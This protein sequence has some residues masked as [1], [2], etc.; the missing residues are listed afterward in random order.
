MNTTVNHHAQSYAV[1]SIRFKDENKLF[2]VDGDDRDRVSARKWH[3]RSCGGYIASGETVDKSRYELYLHNF[4]MDRM[5]FEG[6]G[7]KESVDHINRHG[8]DN[9]KENLRLV[10]QTTQNHN[11]SKKERKVVLPEGCGID[12]NEMPRTVSYIPPESGHHD[13]FAVDVK[14]FPHI[15]NGRYRWKST[16]NGNVSLRNKLHHALFHLKELVNKYPELIG[17]NDEK[18]QLAESF[19]EII[20]KSGF[21]QDVI[22]A[23]LIPTEMT[24]SNFWNDAML[25]PELKTIIKLHDAGQKVANDLPDDMV[26]PPYACYGKASET[27]GDKFYINEGHP[28]L[29]RHRIKSWTTSQEKSVST[30]DKYT[31]LL[32]KM[33]DLK[34]EAVASCPEKVKSH[35]LSKGRKDYGLSEDMPLFKYTGFQANGKIEYFFIQKYHPGLKR[36]GAN[37]WKSSGT[38]KIPRVEKYA[39]FLAKLAELENGGTP[40]TGLSVT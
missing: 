11:Q 30:E 34:D 6:K 17:V 20:K 3:F 9:R 40:D 19:N 13:G 38:M 31:E 18:T 24:A 26:L 28:A 7:Q 4:I 16:R 25:T 12:P 1:F 2:V 21:P 32:A 29:K 33:E 8:P 22:D 5:M 23:N 35:P 39:A 37:Q 15:G 27:R 10:S 36:L 14:G